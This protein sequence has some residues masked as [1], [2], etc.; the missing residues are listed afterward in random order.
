MKLQLDWS[1]KLIFCSSVK[2]KPSSAQGRRMFS[3]D[4]PHEEDE[5]L[6]VIV[7]EKSPS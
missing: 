6:K 3:E 1:L 5:A 2:K 7:K 4:A